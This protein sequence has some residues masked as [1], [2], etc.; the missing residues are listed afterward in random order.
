MHWGMLMAK[1]L[2]G[3]RW[4]GISTVS[5]SHPCIP[6]LSSPLASLLSQTIHILFIIYELQ[7]LARPRHDCTTKRNGRDAV[8]IGS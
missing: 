6:V 1:L 7:L 4:H 3:V 5:R 2:S 8:N